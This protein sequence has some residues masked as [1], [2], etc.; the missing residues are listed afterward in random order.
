MV[1]FTE[2]C[3]NIFHDT[4]GER[5]L[6]FVF[7]IDAVVKSLKMLGFVSKM[8]SNFKNAITLK[9]LFIS[10]VRS[11]LENAFQIWSPHD[12]K[13]IYK[14]ERNQKKFIK[15]LNYR[16]DL[17]NSPRECESFFIEHKFLRLEKRALLDTIWSFTRYQIISPLIYKYVY[18]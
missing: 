11:R 8:S 4:F 2:H 15:S 14:M 10:L 16:F 5:K 3:I 12:R 18:N 7:H 13:Y 9:T 6:S 1:R 17:N